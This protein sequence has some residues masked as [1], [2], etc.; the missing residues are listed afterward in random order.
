MTRTLLVTIAAAGLLPAAAPQDP[1]KAPAPAQK[2][3]ERYQEKVPGTAEQ[4]ELL[5]IPGGTFTMGSPATEKGRGDDEGPQVQVTVEPFWMAKTEITWLQYDGFN[6]DEDWPMG[7]KPDGMTRPTPPYTDMTFGMGR[8]RHPA[9]CM[10]QEAARH[11]CAW[12][13]RKTG[14]FYRLPTEA[15]WEWACRAGAATAYGFGDD[16]ARLD[17]FAWSAAN[18]ENKYHEVGLKK[19]NAWGLHDMHGNVAEWCLDEY[20][21]DAYAA[22]R[23]AGPRVHPFFVPTKA[24]PHVVRGGSWQDL[25]ALLRSAARR[26]SVLAWKA[27]DPQIPKSRWYLTDAPFVGFRVVRP[28]REPSAEEKQRHQGF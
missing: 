16:P 18:S 1:A 6:L 22:E 10:T 12:L 15:E 17:E 27:R 24:Y 4:L 5:P 25:S 7:K 9:I 2:G 11:Y 8:D 28:L 19:P 26:G 23:G 21:A 3:F 14:R 13:S 20:L